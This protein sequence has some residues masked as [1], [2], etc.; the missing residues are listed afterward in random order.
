M[1]DE[2]MIDKYR[3]VSVV[4]EGGMGKVYRAV[5]PTLKRDIIIKRLSISSKKILSERF[6]REAQIMMDFHHESI[7]SVY[8]H[9]KHGTSYYIAMEF[10]DGVPLDEL[11][12]RKKKIP[13]LAAALIFREICKGL[14]YAHDKGVI[15]RDI[16][17][18]N[19]LISR[20]GEVKLFDFGIA[21]LEED[22][23]EKDLTKTGMMM[24]TPSYM[25]PEQ[26]ADAKR[27]DKRSDIYS[28]GVMLYQMLTGKKAFPGNFSADTIRR[29][30][31]GQYERP[32]KMVPNLP[33]F[34]DK[35]LKKTMHHRARQRFRDLEP[36]I[37]KLDRHLAKYKSQEDVHNAIRA[38]LHSSPDK[39]SSFDKVPR[40]RRGRLGL[41]VAAA[42][43]LFAG[44]IGFLLL[45]YTP[46]PELYW[47]AAAGRDRGS[48][49][50]RVVVPV[51]Y[52]KSPSDV[53]TEVKFTRSVP[54][55]GKKRSPPE[56][57]VYRLAP[58]PAVL[59]FIGSIGKKEKKQ[60]TVLT[61]NALYLPAGQYTLEMTVEQEKY[62][63][64]FYLNPLMVQKR[65]PDSPEKRKIFSF[66]L[67]APDGAEIPVTHVVRDAA[68]KAD[69]TRI[70]RITYL[71][72]SYWADW[73][74]SRGVVPR[75]RK[76]RFR[77][78][79][80]DY[81][82]QVVDV[83]LP[84][85]MNS[86]TV[87]IELAKGPGMIVIA[88][89]TDNLEILF[90]NRK[91]YYAGGRNRSFIKFGRTKKGEKSFT[92]DEGDYVMT[93]QKDKTITNVSV[94]VRAGGTTRLRVAYDA[95][96]KKI[97]VTR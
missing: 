82:A 3:I 28:M 56:V 83:P 32:R 4:G 26:L 33:H 22:E 27:V 51:T 7:V 43:V 76:Q 95:K 21:M 80:P 77:Y 86:L 96:D 70:A 46:L 6:R 54:P 11:I 50:V 2:K 41:L 55:V 81:E 44:F 37:H 24:G 62:A 48:L 74:R 12:E 66:S 14:K 88:A 45:P 34:F 8:D 93:L 29:I 40:S 30:S 57:S 69:I 63:S 58:K 23:T 91:E 79:A 67:S 5:H 20:T 92:L 64:S 10:V 13:P 49:E 19:V 1:P 52:Y 16:K 89:N 65:I 75:G 42:V 31:K 87:N 35:I 97:T 60:P 72:G 47:E 90:D 39:D 25:S 9:F 73:K 59:E 85:E 94:S 68:T 84:R 78:D 38:F 17:P 15:H 71:Y 61:T 18:S 36:V 53:Y